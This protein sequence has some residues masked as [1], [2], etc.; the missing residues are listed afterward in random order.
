MII[1]S[2]IRRAFILTAVLLVLGALSFFVSLAVVFAGMT[3][4]GVD[5]AECGIVF[6]AGVVPLRDSLGNVVGSVAGPGIERRTETAAELYGQNKLKKLILTG[7]KG[8]G[9]RRS[10]A[11]VMRDVAVQH[12]VDPLDIIIEE[13]ATSTRENLL[14]SRP[15]TKDCESVLAISDAFHLSRIRFLAWQQGW[16]LPTY[17]VEETIDPW[18]EVRSIIREALGILFY[19]VN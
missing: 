12:G 8:E 2:L 13:Q 17:P 15:L 1:R 9:M 3:G 7:G 6:G 11:A 5:K 4:N 16:S 14:F 18:F 19:S 10:E